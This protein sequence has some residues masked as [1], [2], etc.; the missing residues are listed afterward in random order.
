MRVRGG[1]GWAGGAGWQQLYLNNNKKM[2]PKNTVNIQK[3]SEKEEQIGAINMSR[4]FFLEVTLRC[5]HFM[6]DT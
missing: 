3:N 4:Y 1:D 5:I 2:A 6:P